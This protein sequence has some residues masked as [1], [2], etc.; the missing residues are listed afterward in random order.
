LPK[1]AVL[2]YT[3]ARVGA[4]AKLTVKNLVHDGSHYTLRFSEKGGKSREIPVRHDLE[5][6]VLAY[7]RAAAIAVT[8]R[9][10]TS[11]S[12]ALQNQPRLLGGFSSTT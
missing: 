8:G 10:K 12:W 11:H 1:D 9:F 4:V 7:V 3:A 2:V 5:L 6:L